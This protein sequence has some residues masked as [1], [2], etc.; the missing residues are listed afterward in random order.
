[1][2]IPATRRDEDTKKHRPGCDETGSVTFLAMA[3]ILA[4]PEFYT[5]CPEYFFLRDS[6]LAVASWWLDNQQ[7]RLAPF[8]LQSLLN[9]FAHHT[10]DMQE[11]F[12]SRGPASVVRFLEQRQGYHPGG[13]IVYYTVG[14]SLRPGGLHF[15]TEQGG[16][17]GNDARDHT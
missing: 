15:H 17:D 13:F 12:Q 1:M 7:G 8:R 10:L 4:T 14:R 11:A 16:S 9:K 2:S 3:R 5:R 6:G